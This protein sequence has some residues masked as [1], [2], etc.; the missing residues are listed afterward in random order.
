M[1]KNLDKIK[2]SKHYKQ[3]DENTLI[4]GF[5]KMSVDFLI[6]CEEERIDECIK[7]WFNRNMN[8]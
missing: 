1:Y 3:L 8:W 4:G 2:E 5:V 7:N 6:I